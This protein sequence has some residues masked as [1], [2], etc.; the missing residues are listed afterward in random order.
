M[1]PIEPCIEDKLNQPSEARRE[2]VSKSQFEIQGKNQSYR[3]NTNLYTIQVQN[4]RVKK[5]IWSWSKLTMRNKFQIFLSHNVPY[6]AMHTWQTWPTRRE[7]VSKSQFEIQWQNKS[8][9]ARIINK[10]NWNRKNE[11]QDIPHRFPPLNFTLL[12]SIDALPIE[13]C[14]GEDQTLT[15]TQRDEK[16]KR[17]KKTWSPWDP[18]R[19]RGTRTCGGAAIARRG[20]QN[21]AGRGKNWWEFHRW[22]VPF[23]FSICRGGRPVP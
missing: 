22:A 9:G 10:R 12:L 8:Y 11:F 1:F 20:R 3:R 17:G 5:V 16:R 4:P 7:L 6:R 2:L 18:R 13:P 15:P 19:R 14:T 23:P 21:H